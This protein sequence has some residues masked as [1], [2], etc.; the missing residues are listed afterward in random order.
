M[1]GE[2]T[3]RMSSSFGELFG[4]LLF[5]CFFAEFTRLAVLSVNP[6]LNSRKSRHTLYLSFSLITRKETKRTEISSKAPVTCP[7]PTTHTLTRL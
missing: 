6:V 7:P 3:S 2:K 1:F 5:F 4:V